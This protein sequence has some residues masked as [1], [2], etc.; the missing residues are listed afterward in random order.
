MNATLAAMS[1]GVDYFSHRDYAG[2]P[3]PW[4]GEQPAHVVERA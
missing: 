4:E 2:R 1:G 3:D